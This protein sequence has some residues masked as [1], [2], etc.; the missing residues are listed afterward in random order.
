MLSGYRIP[1][2]AWTWVTWEG[3]RCILAIISRDTGAEFDERG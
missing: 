3:V 1:G 2:G